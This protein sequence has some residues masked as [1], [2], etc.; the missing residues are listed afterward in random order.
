MKVEMTKIKI[1]FLITAIVIFTAVCNKNDEPE[2]YSD[3]SRFL[4]DKIYDYNN[5][6]VGDYIYNESNRL[7][8]IV[9][10]D[11]INYRSIEYEFEYEND[12]VY[13][14]KYTEYHYSQDDTSQ[15]TYNIMLLYNQQGQIKRRETYINGNLIGYN[16]YKYYINGKLRCLADDNGEENIFITY[17]ESENA[18]Q[19][20]WLYEDI[21]FNPGVIVEKYRNFK[22]DNR[23]RPNFG[24][25]YIFQIEP[26]PWFGDEAE[27]EKNI[28]INNMIEYVESGTKWEYSYNENGLPSTIE[29]K[30]KDIE[31][32][33]PMILRITYREI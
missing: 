15:F 3:N 10:L 14:I 13:D 22:Y 11:P 29:T 5:N 25:N 17:S 8:N 12:K 30:W 6:L 24:I 21:W 26:L 23:P 31:T 33:E 19:V 18:I 2:S 28:S 4:V 1:M 16:N 20:K 9:F 32:E 7:T 27:L